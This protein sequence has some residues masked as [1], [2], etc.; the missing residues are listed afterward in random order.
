MS[1]GSVEEEVSLTKEITKMVLKHSYNI[2]TPNTPK[3][4]ACD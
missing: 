4:E 3:R 2:Q 1:T